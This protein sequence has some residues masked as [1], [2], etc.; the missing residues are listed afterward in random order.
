MNELE[1]IR[2]LTYAKF[3]YISYVKQNGH[4][5]YRQSMS[6][7]DYFR[8]CWWESLVTSVFKG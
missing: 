2:C 7:L 5:E 8:L 1:E 4:I 6:Q 3:Q